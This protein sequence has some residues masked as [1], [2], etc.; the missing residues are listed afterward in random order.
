MSKYGSGEDRAE[1]DIQ[2]RAKA[3]LGDKAG[4]QATYNIGLSCLQDTGPEAAVQHSS[5]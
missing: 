2:H 1:T 3:H 5:G 4:D